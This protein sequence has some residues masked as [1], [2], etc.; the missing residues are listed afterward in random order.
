M[1]SE[2][3]SYT[4]AQTKEVYIN[5][6]TD[7]SFS[8]NTSVDDA[9]VRLYIVDDGA[10]YI[11][12]VAADLTATASGGVVTFA[13]LD[14]S[15]FDDHDGK[16]NIFAST[17]TDHNIRYKIMDLILDT[18]APQVPQAPT[19][20]NGSDTYREGFV[21]STNTD[22][23][24]KDTQIS[25]TGCAEA[26]STLKVYTRTNDDP[27]DV[28]TESGDEVQADG[29]A[30]VYTSG[31]TQ[32]DGQT[33]T[34]T[35]SDTT[36]DG[37][38]IA[39]QNFIVVKAFDLASNESDNSGVLDIF[40]DKGID[41]TTSTVGLQTDSTTTTDHSPEFKV[42]NIE[43]ESFV[44]L[45]IWED[46]IQT[47]ETDVD[48]VIQT[49]ELTLISVVDTLGEANDYSDVLLDIGHDVPGYT[50]TTGLNVDSS[51]LSEGEHILTAVIVDVVGNE[52]GYLTNSTFT[53]VHLSADRPADLSFEAA[54]YVTIFNDTYYTNQTTNIT[55]TGI[56]QRDNTVKALLFNGTDYD[57]L[58]PT[59]TPTV[60]SGGLFS[61]ELPEFTSGD[62]NYTLTAQA[63][64]NGTDFFQSNDD[65]NL[66]IDQKS[67]VFAGHIEDEN[68]S[69]VDNTTTELSV[70]IVGLDEL[71]PTNY[72]DFS[73]KD[74]TTPTPIVIFAA[75]VIEDQNYL[76]RGDSFV[77][78]TGVT[79]VDL[80][81]AIL[82][83]VAT[84]TISDVLGN[85][86]TVSSIMSSPQLDISPSDAFSVPTSSQSI[87]VSA[88]NDI[89]RVVLTGDNYNKCNVAHEAI[90]NPLFDAETQPYV[91]V[92]TVTGLAA[93]TETIDQ[94]TSNGTTICY[95]SSDTTATTYRFFNVQNIDTTAPD[96]DL[97]A[98]TY[99]TPAQ[100]KTYYFTAADINEPQ[101]GF[102]FEFLTIPDTASITDIETARSYC[103]N[104][105]GGY[106]ATDFKSE[107][108]L[109]RH[110]LGRDSI[111]N[112][113]D[114]I[115]DGTFTSK[116][117]GNS[118]GFRINA[119]ESYNYG[120]DLSD[121]YIEFGGS[122]HLWRE[123][124]YNSNGTFYVSF[125]TD[126]SNN[127]LGT[128]ADD[129]RLRVT[130]TDSGIVHFD[131]L[132]STNSKKVENPDTEP[133]TIFQFSSGATN[134]TVDKPHRVEVFHNPI[135]FDKETDNGKYLCVGVSDAAGVEAWEAIEVQNIDTTYPTITVAQSN[136][137]Y[138]AGSNEEVSASYLKTSDTTIDDKAACA[139]ATGYTSYTLLEDITT[140]AGESICF[141]VT[142]I[143]GNTTYAHSSDAIE[144]LNNLTLY[145]NDGT[146]L[147]P[148]TFGDRAGTTSESVGIIFTAANGGT[149]ATQSRFNIHVDGSDTYSSRTSRSG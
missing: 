5:K 104:T 13:D 27:V 49:D 42:T 88:P 93:T 140:T 146:T 98:D 91:A 131:N 132:F 92:D 108:G 105:V 102:I 52:S 36:L 87:S 40:V 85:V 123:V 26:N 19:L 75:S 128:P 12:P 64:S 43:K 83:L 77:I 119:D 37:D 141:T 31:G 23:I 41:V 109:Y 63:S 79:S 114:P 117:S 136:N 54:D 25:I 61:I 44:E 56:T 72:T 149:L 10:P 58:T 148:G 139:T 1:A 120:E 100:E 51:N 134:L 116:S 9:E 60:S 55:L 20:T 28:Y 144:V 69:H 24:T 115:Y 82:P 73:I 14:L 16:K 142:D 122:R 94:E 35:L 7:L 125:H 137:A 39:K 147:A 32:Y 107:G 78:N 47:G 22:R 2:D 34:S 76:D 113:E 110:E 84:I 106:N 18:Q 70:T 96:L 50:P 95:R 71:S 89:D 118:T 59:Q 127:Y 48:G 4:D 3:I 29:E 112:E 81:S 11:D 126:E 21:G 133:R 45:Y 124:A 30:C 38:D 15:S 143:A 135:T 74:S 145:Q 8:A 6:T 65:I 130:N 68:G 90:L 17:N 53:F 101:Y 80:S 46:K 111:T 57:E 103:T 67:P 86:T 121:K 97:H 66:T 33:Y 138:F 129:T 99:D 62:G